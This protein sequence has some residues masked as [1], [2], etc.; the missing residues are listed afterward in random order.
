[1]IFRRRLDIEPGPSEPRE[2]TQPRAGCGYLA[3][4]RWARTHRGN[5]KE[6]TVEDLYLE[7]LAPDQ[8]WECFWERFQEGVA[9]V[10]AEDDE[11][12]GVAL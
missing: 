9:F 8:S 4:E 10:R 6:A 7:R 5:A 12:P 1:M 11:P 3:G 2:W